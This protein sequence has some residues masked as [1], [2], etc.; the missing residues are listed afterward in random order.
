MSEEK[1][2]NQ[3]Q[4]PYAY[5]G[6]ERVI[7]ER[8]RLSIVTSLA[9]NPRGLVFSDLK[10]FCA[11]TD[12]NLNR[13]LAVLQQAGAVEIAKSFKNGRSVTICR[14][15]EDGHHRLVDYLTQMEKVLADAAKA[16]ARWAKDNR[17]PEPA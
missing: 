14:L 13:H 15:T 1:T 17:G 16:Q 8:A 2:S 5:E 4:A 11:L 7:H 6:L 10:E 9:A 3:D 12:G